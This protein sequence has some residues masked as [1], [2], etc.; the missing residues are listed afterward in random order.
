MFNYFSNLSNETNE[1]TVINMISKGTMIT[2][3]MSCGGD[4]R[5]DGHLEGN[6]ANEG[7]LVT[8]PDSE[9][10]GDIN[11]G[12][13]KI[14]GT[15]IGNITVN[16]TLEIEKSARVEGI[17]VS[18]GLIIHEGADLKAEISSRNKSIQKPMDNK[19]VNKTSDFSRAAVL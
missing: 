1:L 10:K 9:I 12:S 11:V 3:N 18:N 19:I 5:I 6:I 16:G 4:I 17:I 13:A 8:G 7:K 2:G 14:G 15:I